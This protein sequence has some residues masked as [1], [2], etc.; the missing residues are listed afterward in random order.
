MLSHRKQ[1]SLSPL[2]L[3]SCCVAP[4]YQGCCVLWITLCSGSKCQSIQI[5]I[6]TFSGLELMAHRNEG[7]EYWCRP[8]VCQ[9]SV[10][11]LHTVMVPSLSQVPPQ[12]AVAV[13]MFHF[14]REKGDLGF[15]QYHCLYSQADKCLQWLVSANKELFQNFAPEI[16]SK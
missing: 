5:I 15:L 6:T 7:S 11:P 4:T 1:L 14:R 12:P 8:G 16:D 2:T 9:S 10:F 13:M 3:Q